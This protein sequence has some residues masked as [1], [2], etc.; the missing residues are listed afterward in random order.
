MVYP[1]YLIISISMPALSSFCI[2]IL[3]NTTAESQVCYMSWET[4]VQNHLEA[5]VSWCYE[6]LICESWEGL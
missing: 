6:T 3:S 2:T 4:D 1:N 5:T